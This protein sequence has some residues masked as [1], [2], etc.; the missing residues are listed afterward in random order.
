MPSVAVHDVR[1][2]LWCQVRAQE[3][4]LRDSRAR[5]P[6]VTAGILLGG[7]GELVDG[8]VLRQILQWHH[9]VAEPFPPDS[10]RKLEP[11]SLGDGLFYAFTRLMTAVGLGLLWRASTQPRALW[12]TRAFAGSLAIGWGL[13]NLIEG[14]V[15]HHLL[16]IHHV[17]PGL[18]NL[19]G[20]WR[21]SHSAPCW[22][23]A[24]GCWR[25]QRLVRV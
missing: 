9:M 6:L 8:I 17:R 13:S 16:G 19:P 18:T 5:S 14:I 4:E 2:R 21:S 10:V 20:I 3:D 7:L 12:S 23:S 22:W 15:D 25:N 11:S 24:G 1:R